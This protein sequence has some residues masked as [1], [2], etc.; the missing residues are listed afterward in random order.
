MS[1]MLSAMRG[2]KKHLLEA[3]LP[4]LRPILEEFAAQLE[5][6]LAEDPSGPG[7]TVVA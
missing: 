3:A 7:A 5:E 4:Q 1:V 6:A 2:Q